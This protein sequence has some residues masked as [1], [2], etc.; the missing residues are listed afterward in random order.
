[1]TKLQSLDMNQLR[2]EYEEFKA[3]E[4]GPDDRV[5]YDGPM[6]PFTRWAQREQD[7]LMEEIEAAGGIEAWRALPAQVAARAGPRLTIDNIW[8]EIGEEEAARQRQAA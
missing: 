2:R 4:W 3:R 7:I 6:D 8:R 5:F 1:M